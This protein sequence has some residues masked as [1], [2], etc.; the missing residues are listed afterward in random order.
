[1]KKIFALL[2]ISFSSFQAVLSQEK[3]ETLLGGNLKFSNLGV[4]VE[5]GFQFTQL[6]GEG[7]GFFQFRGGVILN[8]KITLGGFYGSLINEVR[9]ASL[10]SG[11]PQAAHLDSYTAGGFIEYTLFSNKLV[12]F[13]FPLAI[14]MMEIEIDEEGRN[15]D[16]DERKNLFFEP[17]AQVEVNLHK[18][19]RLHAGLGYRIMGSTIE[20]ATGVPQA[21]NN[22]TFQVGLKMGVFNFKNL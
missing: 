1:M 4:M 2:A 11:L 9:P 10:D 12:H 7:A 19:A 18:F 3:E 20:N 13:T 14:G 16:Y 22:L 5:P 8:D 6:A 17:R 15:F 21:N